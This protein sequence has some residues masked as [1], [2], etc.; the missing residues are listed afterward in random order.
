MGGLDHRSRDTGGPRS[1][2]DQ[3]GILAREPEP[4]TRLEASSFNCR[5]AA[6]RLRGEW[7]GST[8]VSDSCA[9]AQAPSSPSVTAISAT[10]SGPS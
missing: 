9:P 3:L 8:T 5:T 6:L 1:G 2:Q 4:E 7:R 10:G